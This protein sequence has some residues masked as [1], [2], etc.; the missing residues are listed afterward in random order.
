MVL[1]HVE[2]KGTHLNP[3]SELKGGEQNECQQ[4]VKKTKT[5]REKRQQDIDHY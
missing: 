1:S 5:S 3:A 4:L 2:S